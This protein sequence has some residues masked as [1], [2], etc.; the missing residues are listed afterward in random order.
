MSELNTSIHMLCEEF[1]GANMSVKE[2]E[3][4]NKYCKHLKE[5]LKYKEYT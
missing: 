4:V 5:T 3:Q 2:T 1:W